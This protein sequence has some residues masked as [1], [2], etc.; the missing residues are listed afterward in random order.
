[1]RQWLVAGSLALLLALAPSAAGAQSAHVVQQWSGNG[2]QQTTEPFAVA[3]ADW[4]ITWT[5]QDRGA[6]PGYLTI[7][8]YNAD[9]RR[10]AGAV[11]APVGSPSGNVTEHNGPGRFFL[12]IDGANTDWSVEVAD[13]R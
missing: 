8:I 3:S 2:V 12:V 7:T 4:T 5:T 10:P 13:Q 11:S 6:I 9:T 1:M